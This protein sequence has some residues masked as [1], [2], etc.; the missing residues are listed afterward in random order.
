MSGETYVASLASVTARGGHLYVL[1]FS[2]A[3]PDTGPH[4][5]TQEELRAAFTPS[6]G[7]RVASIRPERIETTF[8]AQGVPAWLATI[9]RTA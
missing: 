1:C 4:P 5:V 8:N 7:W 6:R 3:G 9:E 2:D